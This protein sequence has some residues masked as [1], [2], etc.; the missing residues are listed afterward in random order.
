MVSPEHGVRD[1]RI[2]VLVAVLEISESFE[3]WI[4]H[5]YPMTPCDVV[6]AWKCELNSSFGLLSIY[7][8]SFALFPVMAEHST[9]PAQISGTRS[10]LK[11]MK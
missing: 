11:V 3:A 4:F 8:H 5:S 7:T 10:I 2:G 6:Q 9:N 1:L